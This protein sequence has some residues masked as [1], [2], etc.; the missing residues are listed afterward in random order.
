MTACDKDIE[1]TLLNA[2]ADTIGPVRFEMWFGNNTSIKCCETVVCITASS[3]FA[4]DWIRTNYALE[5]RTT[6]RALLGEK[7]DVE[8]TSTQNGEKFLKLDAERPENARAVAQSRGLSS[9]PTAVSSEKNVRSAWKNPLK[10]KN[11]K[12]MIGQPVPV[13]PTYPKA[14]EDICA[15]AEVLNGTPQR[16]EQLLD[17]KKKCAGGSRNR[18]QKFGQIR[19]PSAIYYLL[20]ETNTKET[21]SKKMSAK[22]MSVAR[23]NSVSHSTPRLNVVY[24]HIA[25]KSGANDQAFPGSLSSGSLSPGPLSNDFPSICHAPCEKE[26]KLPLGEG[27]TIDAKSRNSSQHEVPGKES[28]SEAVKKSHE[29][30]SHGLPSGQKVATVRKSAPPSSSAAG[31]VSASAFERFIVAPSNRLAVHAAELAI[32]YSGKINPIYIYGPTSVGKTHLLESIR[33]ELRRDPRGKQ[34]LLM[35]A[36]QFTSLFIEGLKQGMPLFRNK[37]RNISTFLVDDIQFFSGKAST[38]TEFWRTI[39]TLKNQ[40]V[41]I[42]LTGDRSVGALAEILKPEIVSRLEAGMHCEIRSAEYETLL[43]IF[44]QMAAARNIGL[45]DE[46]CRFVV[47]HLTTHARQLSGAINRLHA[48]ILTTGRPV[49]FEV[50]ES[51]LEDMIRNNR[52]SVRLQDIE[53]AVCE[54]FQLNGQSLQSKSRAKQVTQPR[55]LAMWLARKY[56]RLAFSEIGKYFG[57]RSHSTVVSAQKKVNQWLQDEPEMEISDLSMSLNDIVQKLERLLQTGC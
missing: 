16:Q 4:A 1:R 32:R 20:Q 17:S 5:I 6:C 52:R 40:G 37:F 21:D 26:V 25:A 22:D 43:A 30:K 10:P 41:Q 23:S 7:Y 18:L 27:K 34:P 53:K 29:L 46:V 35:T 38:Q 57:S 54:T 31:A 56:T 14:H 33:R 2:I 51:A 15:K 8:I 12:N 49:T 13:E 47:S 45:S 11:S 42:V 24:K 48:T 44:Q 55:M 19:Q 36:E 50:A 39:E 9:I 3:V 28:R